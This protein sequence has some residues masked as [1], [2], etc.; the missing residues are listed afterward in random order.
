MFVQGSL[1]FYKSGLTGGVAVIALL[2]ATPGFAQQAQQAVQAQPS[3]SAM[4]NLVGLLVDQ[5]VLTREKGAALMA[6]AK[7]EAAQARA[8]SA[9]QASVATAAQQ[10]ASEPPPPAPGTVRVPYV[11]ETVRA[12]I[13]AE[14][15]SD[16]LAQAKAEHWAAPAQ[17]A[18]DWVRNF[19]IHGDFRFRSASALFS[20]DNATE[21]LNV[22][23]W[24][25]TGPYDPVHDLLPSLNTTRDKINN[26][27][28]RGRINLTATVADRFELGFQLAT[29]DNA[30]PVSTNA[31]LTGG[32][33][34]RDVWIQ[35]AYLK[36]ELIPGVTAMVG[37][38]DNPFHT[39]DLMF[40]P[41]LALDGAYGQVDLGRLVG[42]PG[43][44]LQ[45]RGGAFP[46]QY[47]DA[48]YP[49]TSLAKRN[50]R[51]RYLFSGQVELGKA[52]DNG[53]KTSV[54]AAY[55]DFTYLRGH[56]SEPCDVY[57]ATNVECSTDALRPLYASKGNT[58][59]FLRRFDF[60]QPDDPANPSQP[61]YLGLKFGYRVLELNGMVSVPV[62]SRAIAQLTG[63][64]IRNLAFDPQNLCREGADS[65]P[66]NN[67]ELTNAGNSQQGACDA[68]NPARFVGGN[69]GYGAYFSL[70]DPALF[71]VN[72]RRAPKGAWAVNLAYKYLPSDATLD[73]FTDSD[74]HL[75]GTNAKGY[76]V[77]VA[78]APLDHITFGGRWLS[79][80]QV[81]G[82][83]LA[84]DVLQLDLGVA[85]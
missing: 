62:S 41:D 47:E 15:R 61:Q 83:P 8:A 35:N 12:Q 58:F 63:T 52:F 6:Q 7:A 64:Y 40:D 4:V 49:S 78:W 11:P 59:M 82:P 23:E 68:T 39:T 44:T 66:L 51:D 53:I 48:N 50:F 65:Q 13:R 31:T 1:G 33:Q 18:P 74:F 71:S 54:R 81:S 16:V 67:V 14:L 46:I 17:S 29:G 2:W 56:I 57:S 19:E 36:G 77:G 21:F 84:I 79:A 22:P 60:R 32:F 5:G 76:V 38:F 20:R 34:K 30:G 45:V 70:G 10:L 37:R 42:D 24:N 27:Q 85:F 75:G 3:D 72:P 9:A 26:L 55:H 80:N 25:A 73:A 28:I 43:F 69:Q